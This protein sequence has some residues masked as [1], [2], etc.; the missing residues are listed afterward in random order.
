MPTITTASGR[1]PRANSDSAA[2]VLHDAIAAAVQAHIAVR[3]RRIVLF[4]V[5]LARGWGVKLPGLPPAEG[6]MS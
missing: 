1:R 5:K 6:G 4:M 3:L 2:A